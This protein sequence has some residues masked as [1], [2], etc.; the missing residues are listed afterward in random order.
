MGLDTRRLR[1]FTR[2][3]ELGSLGRAADDLHMAQPALSQHLAA[4]E[5][6]FGVK[7]LIRS[8][9]G[10]T[11][12]AAGR[13]L[14]RHAQQILRQVQQAQSAVRSSSEGISGRVA[15]GMP[16]GAAASPMPV[17]LLRSAK[18]RYPG[19]TLSITEGMSGTIRDQLVGGRLDFAL[20]YQG[21]AS[22]VIEYQPVYQESLKLVIPKALANEIAGT[23]TFDLAEI[24][25][26]E[27][28]MPSPEHELR[29]LIDQHLT[30]CG[31]APHCGFEVDSLQIARALLGN[32]V[33]PALLSSG[34]AHVLADEMGCN[35]LPTRPNFTVTLALC[36]ATG[37]TLSEPA[38]TIFGL[39]AEVIRDLV[40]T[41]N[42]EG[43]SL[44]D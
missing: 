6:D 26:Y 15:I 20:L 44:L 23:E 27:L 37:F 7:L 38:H 30:R 35:V 9:Q 28:I 8:H 17:A 22:K 13:E 29:R 12:T 24:V 31:I 33:G 5:T 25:R 34:T 42:W 1:Y 41:G 36:T 32:G 21:G 14:Y 4:L 11:P 3:V 18:E 39:M 10:T 40:L 16:P 43:V 2:I 19:I